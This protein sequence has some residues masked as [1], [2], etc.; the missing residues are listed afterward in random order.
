MRK[1]R[2]NF[3]SGNNSYNVTENKNKTH[4]HL[5]LLSTV[6]LQIRGQRW[7]TN[8]KSSWHQICP[9]SPFLHR[10]RSW[11]WAAW[12][13]WSGCRAQKRVSS[14]SPW[15]YSPCLLAGGSS[16]RRVKG[17]SLQ[18]HHPSREEIFGEQK[19]DTTLNQ[20]PAD[21]AMWPPSPCNSPSV[22]ASG[23]L[24]W[25]HFCPDEGRVRKWNEKQFL[26]L[27]I[28]TTPKKTV[29][30]KTVNKEEY[31]T[32]NGKDR[33]LITTKMC[34]WNLEH[35]SGWASQGSSLAAPGRKLQFCQCHSFPV[36]QETFTEQL[37]W[38]HVTKT[39]K[40]AM[41][42]CTSYRGTAFHHRY[43][44]NQICISI[45]C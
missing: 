39:R 44:I 7:Q 43:L 16:C 23:C 31:N 28:N 36:D 15:E 21:T 2:N 4:L 34:A 20:S 3:V 42:K 6:M 9:S 27:S 10:T 11:P 13:W 18:L 32:V 33:L 30:E 40:S 8:R 1:I 41:K 38:E 22:W 29:M 35:A 45:T 5:T 37:H 14:D 25:R 19:R 17:A 24:N 26:M 12:G